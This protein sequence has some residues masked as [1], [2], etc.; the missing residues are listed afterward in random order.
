M[1]QINYV[2]EH[3]WAGKLG[4][5]LVLTLFISSLLSAFSYFK[6]VRREDK[7]WLILGRGAFITHAASVFSVI[8]LIF[9]IMVQKYY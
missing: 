6:N 5:F 7:G 1:D 2:G 8:G 4:H 9:Y 3:L